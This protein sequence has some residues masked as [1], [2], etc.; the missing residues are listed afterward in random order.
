MPDFHSPMQLAL[1]GL[2]QSDAALKHLIVISDGDPSPPTPALVQQFVD[3]KVSVSMIAINPHGGR[4]ISIMQAISQQTGGRYYFPE[5]PAA[6]PSIFIKEAKT[7]K[8]SMLQ[9]KTFTPAVEVPSPILKGIEQVPPLRGYVLTTAKPR[10]STILRVPPDKDAPDQLDPLLATW[11]FGLGSTAAWTSDLGASWA[12]D[13]IGWEK[14]RAFVKQ[15]AQ[16]VSRVEQANDLRLST[17]AAGNNGVV[18]VEDFARDE[19]FLE[20]AARITGPRGDTIDLPLRQTGSRRYQAQFPLSGKGRYQVSVAA[21]GRPGKE[22]APEQIFG[23][24]AVPYSPEYLNF[25]SNPQLL[26]QIAARTGGRVLD[27]ST[28]DIFHPA[29][30]FHESSRPVFDWLLI[31]LA[32]LLPIDVAVRRVQLDWTVIRGW[33]TFGGKAEESTT[34]MGA[35]LGRKRR[36]EASLATAPEGIPKPAIKA[37]PSVAPKP[38]AAPPAPTPGDS[39]ESISTTERLLARKRQRDQ[40]QK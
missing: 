11:R 13:W 16:D 3:A 15:L 17:F 14:Y 36:V 7:L 4:D 32:C 21:A 40:D 20:V 10:A 25:R 38:T 35:L 34:T 1:A 12:Q 27:G 29:R 31:F 39:P 18:S 28:A 6:L 26:Q 37:A 33:F 30:Q 5:D 22:N 24:F 23:G 19:A 2:Q 9:N 8:R